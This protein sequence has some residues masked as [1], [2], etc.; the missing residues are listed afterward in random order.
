MSDEFAVLLCRSH[1]RAL[2]AAG[3]DR[4][5]WQDVQIDPTP[6]AQQLWRE[7]RDPLP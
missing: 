3:D 5:W 1:H 4:V 6:F 7:T 2:H